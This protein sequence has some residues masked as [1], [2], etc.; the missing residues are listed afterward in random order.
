MHILKASDYVIAQGF[1]YPHRVETVENRARQRGLD[2]REGLERHLNK[3]PESPTAFVDATLF[4]I[5][6]SPTLDIAKL[7][8][9]KAKATVLR[10]GDEV[11]IERYC[12]AVRVHGER[13]SNPIAFTRTWP[14]KP[15]LEVAE[16]KLD[17]RR[18][19]HWDIEGTEGF[20]HYYSALKAYRE[21]IAAEH[22]AKEAAEREAR[23]A[24]LD[25]AAG[26][27]GNRALAEYIIGL[28]DRTAQVDGYTDNLFERVREI[29][30]H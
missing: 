15:S 5:S 1:H 13:V 21:G 29:E 20:E 10:D 12:Y 2:P 30:A 3:F 14:K 6:D 25:A 17:W 4:V 18:D 27:N 11:E 22:E 8:E 24:E 7:P 16:L 26:L 23:I 9:T 28:E 19:P